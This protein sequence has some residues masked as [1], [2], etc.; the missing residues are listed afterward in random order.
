MS[1]IDH[2]RLR[3]EKAVRNVTTSATLQ[4]VTLSESETIRQWY[5]IDS[6]ARTGLMHDQ[7]SRHKAEDSQIPNPYGCGAIG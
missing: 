6:P 5:A 7:P 2:D 3:R 1:A 4:A